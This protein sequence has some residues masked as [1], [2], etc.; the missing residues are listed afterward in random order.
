MV[1]PL[2]LGGGG[3][4]G[5]GVVETWLSEMYGI[6]EP[7][8]Q[9]F[10]EDGAQKLSFIKFLGALFFKGYHIKYTQVTTIN[11]YMYLLIEIRHILT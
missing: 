8:M 10:N 1:G 7:F 9:G 5:G 2:N 6:V 11:M 3:G 4:G